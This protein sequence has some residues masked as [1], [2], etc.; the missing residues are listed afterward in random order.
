MTT[1]S[2]TEIEAVTAQALRQHGAADWVADAVARAVRRVEET[3]NV[4]CGL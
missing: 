2:L 4:I 1:V 3:G